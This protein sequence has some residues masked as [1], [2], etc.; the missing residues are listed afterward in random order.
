MQNIKGN[1]NFSAQMESMF[2]FDLI[3]YTIAINKDIM[4]DKCA[5]LHII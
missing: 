1:F 4:T 5:I 2:N 3:M